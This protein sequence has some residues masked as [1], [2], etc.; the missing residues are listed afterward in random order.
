MKPKMAFV[1]NVYLIVPE[2]LNIDSFVV[3][4]QDTKGNYQGENKHGVK[5]AIVENMSDQVWYKVP[6]TV[7]KESD[8]VKK[9][10]T[11]GPI[12]IRTWHNK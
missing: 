4:K 3:G 10:C 12:E 9:L 7:I 2:L 5:L 11:V 6:M 1:Y 8:M